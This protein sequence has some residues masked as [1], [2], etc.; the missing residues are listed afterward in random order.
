MVFDTKGMW[1]WCG[2]FRTT[3]QQDRDPLSAWVRVFGLPVS[4]V[5]PNDLCQK[6]I[7]CYWIRAQPAQE[8]QASLSCLVGF[9]F[10]VVTQQPEKPEEPKTIWSQV[11]SPQVWEKSNVNKKTL[12]WANRWSEEPW[13]LL[14]IDRSLAWDCVPTGTW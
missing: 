4:T 3:P 7:G 9:P 2:S 5:A 13:G 8:R 14:G 1:K 11:I 12:I 6:L 10:A